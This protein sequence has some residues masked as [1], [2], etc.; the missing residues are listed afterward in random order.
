MY[1][2]SAEIFVTEFEDHKFVEHEMSHT[3]RA[4][5][6]ETI[7]PASGHHFWKSVAICTLLYSWKFFCEAEHVSELRT[8][9]QSNINGRYACCAS[10]CE[11][12]L[13]D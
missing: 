2:R 8:T 7:Q 6:Y 3:Y 12:C 9:A 4:F 11:N 1:L 10:N 5:T 13:P